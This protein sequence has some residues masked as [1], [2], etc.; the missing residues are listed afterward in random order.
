MEYNDMGEH[1]NLCKIIVHPERQ[2][3]KVI[4]NSKNWAE[5]ISQVQKTLEAGH[6]SD[7]GPIRAQPVSKVHHVPPAQCAACYTRY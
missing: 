1:N 2:N 7:T 5:Q 3:K 4:L 6:F